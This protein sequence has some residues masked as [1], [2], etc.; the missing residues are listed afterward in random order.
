MSKEKAIT[1]SLLE[2]TIHNRAVRRWEQESKML[3][4]ALIRSPFS[5]SKLP[6]KSDHAMRDYFVLG[7][8]HTEYP[9]NCE[10][11]LKA[12]FADYDKV[13]DQTIKE[14]EQDEIDRILQSIGGISSFLEDQ[15]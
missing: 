13:K 1:K 6:V 2:E 9:D 15:M 7:E 10:S 3:C 4:D 5:D 8:V 11:I 12:L 14:Y